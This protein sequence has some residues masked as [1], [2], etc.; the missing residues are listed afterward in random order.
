[1]LPKHI[2]AKIWE[3]HKAPRKFYIADIGSIFGTFIK[4]KPNYIYLLEM[5]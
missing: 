5:G 1:M 3:F 4:I 2:F